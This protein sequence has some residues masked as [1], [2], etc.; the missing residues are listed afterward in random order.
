MSRVD[1]LVLVTIVMIMSPRGLAQHSQKFKDL[2]SRGL[3]QNSVGVSA[4]LHTQDNRVRYTTGE[5]VKLELSIRSLSDDLY[6]VETADRDG[7]EMVLQGST[8]EEPRRLVDRHGVLCCSSALKSLGKNP[9]D[10][11]THFYL[12]LQPG[13][14][15]LFIRTKRVSRGWPKPGHYGDG[16]VVTSDVLQLTINPDHK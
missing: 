2:H 6:T 16:P 4:Q 9:V 5:I 1:V 3:K 8:A 12:H 7:D 11:A 13:E 10:V 14:Y 15:S